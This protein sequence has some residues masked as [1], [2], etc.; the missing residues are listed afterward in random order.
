M[1]NLNEYIANKSVI[2][3]YG[4]GRYAF[5]LFLYLEMHNIDVECFLV[6]ASG[7]NKTYW[8]KPI[9]EY[10]TYTGNR[11]TP[12]IVAVDE[13]HHENIANRVD[14]K[15]FDVYYMTHKDIG[16]VINY[17]AKIKM[18]RLQII[19][20]KYYNDTKVNYAIECLAD[21]KMNVIS[22][23]YDVFFEDEYGREYAE[24]R[25]FYKNYSRYKEIDIKLKDGLIRV[26]DVESFLCAY[27]SILVER[28]YNFKPSSMDYVQ[29]LDF[30]SNIGLSLYFY[31][32]NYPNARIEGFEADPYIYEIC[33]HNL[34]SLNYNSRVE[35]HNAAVW[36]NDGEINFYAEGAD[37][38]HVVDG[39]ATREKV[40]KVKCY[41]ALSIV[42]RYSHIDFLKIDIEG[43]ET[44]VLRRIEHELTR[45]DNIF[46][47]YHSCI[48]KP[49][50]LGIVINILINTGFRIYFSADGL[51]H[52]N[53]FMKPV[54]YQ[55]FDGLLNIWGT[56]R[57]E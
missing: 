4:T 13:I 3:L 1:A 31:A 52:K 48:N 50:T 2:N 41:D 42:Q 39:E 35:I 43:S 34:R 54:R 32:K 24:L 55:G 25:R 9:L 12:V 20:S 51:K 44:E 10:N 40:E 27:K 22:K 36:T 57:S 45:V 21:Y 46:V 47:E 5:Y 7:M 11:Q 29:I 16:D 49:Q 18:D 53:P 15:F 30:G 6:S 14:G 19:L 8:N 38:G 56:R 17:L 33:C 28:V 26:P 23:L 37:A